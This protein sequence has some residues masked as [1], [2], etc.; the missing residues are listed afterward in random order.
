MRLNWFS[1]PLANLLSQRM[2]GDA[3]TLL[4]CHAENSH[5]PRVLIGLDKPSRLTDLLQWIYD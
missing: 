3:H 5:F 1:R 2:V 4:G